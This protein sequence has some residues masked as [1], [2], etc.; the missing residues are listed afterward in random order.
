MKE[1]WAKM[2][3][4]IKDAVEVVDGMKKTQERDKNIFI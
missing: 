4:A 1:K 3:G 2:A